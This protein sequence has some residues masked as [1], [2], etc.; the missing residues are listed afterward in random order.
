VENRRKNMSGSQRSVFGS[1]VATGAQQDVTASVGFRPTKV[2]LWNTSTNIGL[3][4]QNSMA[5]ASGLKTLAAGTRTN[6]TANGI[7]PLAAGFRV[8]TD[9]VNVAGNTVHF[10]ATN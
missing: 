6:V 5:D 2:R 10:E 7:T 9:S 1:F 3:E 8:G 4:W